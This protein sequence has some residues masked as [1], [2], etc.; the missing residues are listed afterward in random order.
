MP[1][2]IR[3]GFLVRMLKAG[4]EKTGI[5]QA[6]VAGGVAASALLRRMTEERAVK[7]RGC[8]RIVFGRPEMSGDN[9][10]GVALIGAARYR[11]TEE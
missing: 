2:P 6:L 3:T 1:G 11:N 9:A 10:A 4:A 8:P 7:T 5:R